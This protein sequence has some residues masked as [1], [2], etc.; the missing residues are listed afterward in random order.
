MHL[1]PPGSLSPKGKRLS[2]AAQP[3]LQP[4]PHGCVGEGISQMGKRLL[5]KGTGLAVPHRTL[6]EDG[7]SR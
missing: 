2:K 7:F 3:T 4:W 5:T 1:D 6:T